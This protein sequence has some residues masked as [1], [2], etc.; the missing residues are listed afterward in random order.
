MG[1]YDGVSAMACE[2]R[3]REAELRQQIR[4]RQEG[5]EIGVA[6]PATSPQALRAATADAA[7][8]TV[9]T[10]V[11]SNGIGA[12]AWSVVS[13]LWSGRNGHES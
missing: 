9:E 1:L 10:G 2:E 5:G 6:Q 4:R 3:C 12:R 8:A 13:R 11:V 7:T